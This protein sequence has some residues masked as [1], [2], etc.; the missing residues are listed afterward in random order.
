[1]DGLFMTPSRFVNGLAVALATALL[2][3]CGGGQSTAPQVPISNIQQTSH[4]PTAA[5]T[6]ARHLTLSYKLVVIGTF[7]GPQSFGDPG[8]GA[9]SNISNDGTASGNADTSSSNPLYPA[10]DPI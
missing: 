9:A 8:H 5:T 6:R 1:M 4:P 3:S 2:A 10:F 7:G